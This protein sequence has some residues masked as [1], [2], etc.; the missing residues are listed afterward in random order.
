[1]A[2]ILRLLEVTSNLNATS[3]DHGSEGHTP[4]HFAASHGHAAA[5]LEL[6]H[7]GASPAAAAADGATP[8]HLALSH[9]HR[10]CAEILLQHGADAT[11][12]LSD[13]AAKP[14]DWLF[15]PSR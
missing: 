2:V 11:A 8:L 13:G 14:S 9:N 1:M 12:R 7:A 6:L 15:V 10:R 4:L 5:V 3:N